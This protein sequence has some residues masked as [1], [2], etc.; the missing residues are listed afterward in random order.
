M[1]CGDSPGITAYGHA[2]EIGVCGSSPP[3]W[4]EIEGAQD[5][6]GLPGGS[7]NTADTTTHKA[8]IPH[9]VARNK[10]TLLTRG[11]IS[12][13][14]MQDLSKDSHVRLR[15]AFHSTSAYPFRLVSTDPSEPNQVF[16]GNVTEWGKTAPVDG[17]ISVSV[18]IL[19]DG[20]ITDE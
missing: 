11:T 13:T 7:W 18:S 8:G 3:D 20:D 1:L 4:L 19:I 6:D 2:L 12:F 5:Y 15:Q 17:V 16:M 10:K 14:L 9:P